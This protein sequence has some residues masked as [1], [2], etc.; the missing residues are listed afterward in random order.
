MADKFIMI[1]TGGGSG[2]DPA[3]YVTH[4]Q[5]NTTLEDYVKKTDLEDRLSTPIPFV[6][7]PNI[8]TPSDGQPNVLNL[9]IESTPF[10]IQETAIGEHTGSDWQISTDSQFNTL[11]DFRINDPDNLTTW[12]PGGLNQNT[13]YYVRVKHIS[14][15]LTSEWSDTISFTTGSIVVLT[16]PIINL[17]KTSAGRLVIDP[18]AS[19][20]GF[21]STDASD[22]HIATEW[23]IEH[24]G[25]EVWRKLVTGNNLTEL[26]LP[27]NKIRHDLTN[28]ISVR[29]IS[30]LA[31]SQYTTV[32]EVGATKVNY[33]LWGPFV[34]YPNNVSNLQAAVTKDNTLHTT[35]GG[36]FRHFTLP[37]DGNVW[38]NSPN[39]LLRAR[40]H[41]LSPLLDGN[42]LLTG[43]TG[44]GNDRQHYS[45]FD[46]N[47]NAWVDMGL[48]PTD[49]YEHTQHTLNNGVVILV[50][51]RDTAGRTDRVDLYDPYTDTWSSLRPLPERKRR[52]TGGKLFDGSVIVV[53]GRFNNTITD[54]AYRYY[55]ETN[56]WIEIAKL[57]IKAEF[58]RGTV[59]NDG[60]FYVSGGRNGSTYYSDVYAYNTETDLWTLVSNMPVGVSAHFS[61][62][63]A[64]GTI[65]SGTGTDGSNTRN[66]YVF[67]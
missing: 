48:M 22:I 66:V 4:T 8:I 36:S 24:D 14:G 46:K 62:V 5:L 3:N 18:M 12:I 29:F 59:G 64:N 21:S 25:V 10:S 27:G 35:G 44:S 20:S 37:E 55:P 26:I 53:G 54:T 67:F 63:L 19:V 39:I 60:I 49:R 9:T 40:D 13:T 51:G 23:V 41:G 61:M 45:I 31:V 34:D 1:E 33:N 28:T 47:T 30:N 2:I 6:I 65:M 56:R 32:N 11:V 38:I 58:L 42:L 52:H 43:G 57:P 17:Q 7:K 16:Q 15:Q 50:G